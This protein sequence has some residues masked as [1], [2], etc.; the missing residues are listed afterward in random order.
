MEEVSSYLLTM[1]ILQLAKFYDFHFYPTFVGDSLGT[2]KSCILPVVI[3]S[4]V[5]EGLLFNDKYLFI[6]APRCLDRLLDLYRNAQFSVQL[7]H[8]PAKL[9]AT[10]NPYATEFECTHPYLLSK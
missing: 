9:A 8:R 7:Q 1:V 2:V 4:Q 10:V 3:I 6:K 5:I